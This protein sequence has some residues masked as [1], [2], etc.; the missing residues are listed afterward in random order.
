VRTSLSDD[1]AGRRTARELCLALRGSIPGLTDT[2]RVTAL[3]A[4]KPLARCVP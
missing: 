4:A 3:S 1:R 2:V